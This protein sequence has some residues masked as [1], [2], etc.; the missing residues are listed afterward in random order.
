MIKYNIYEDSQESYCAAIDGVSVEWRRVVNKQEL[1]RKERRKPEQKGVSMGENRNKM[2]WKEKEQGRDDW[3]GQKGK[4]S[5]E[6][7]AP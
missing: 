2:Q 4:G 1:C 7:D 5:N 3:G 6:V